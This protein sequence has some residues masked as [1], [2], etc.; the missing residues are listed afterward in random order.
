MVLFIGRVPHVHI[1]EEKKTQSVLLGV[2]HT[3]DEGEFKNLF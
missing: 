3:I 2:M 1:Y